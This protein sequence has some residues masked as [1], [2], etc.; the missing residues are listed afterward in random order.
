MATLYE[1][2]TKREDL[3]E[4]LNAIEISVTYVYTII[5]CKFLRIMSYAIG[6]IG[7]SL[8]VVNVVRVTKNYQY[9]PTH[10]VSTYIIAW[11]LICLFCWGKRYGFIILIHDKTYL[12]TYLYIIRYFVVW[13]YC[14]HVYTSDHSNHDLH[15]K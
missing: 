6:L 5:H 13:K 9:L 4:K 12:S 1:S 3:I 7:F 2:L 14:V 11:K 15:E 8:D 10:N